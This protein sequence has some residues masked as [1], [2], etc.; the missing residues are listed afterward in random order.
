MLI[1]WELPTCSKYVEE[2][3]LVLL[4]VVAD[5]EGLVPVCDDG[6]RLGVG[7]DKGVG[8]VDCSLEAVEAQR[9]Q[10]VVQ[11]MVEQML[12]GLVVA[13]L[14]NRNLPEVGLGEVGVGPHDLLDLVVVLLGAALQELLDDGADVG[15]EVALAGE[16]VDNARN[17]D[18]AC[19]KERTQVVFSVLDGLVL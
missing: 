5:Y 15:V 13:R 9:D 16:G 2:V 19:C 7:V 1:C 8:V 17:V 14:R 18:L 3:L 11:Q 10:L 12:K 6:I 4:D